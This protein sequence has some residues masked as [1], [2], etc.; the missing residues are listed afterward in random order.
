M[1]KKPD[2]D[3][4]AVLP[5]LESK[6]IALLQSLQPSD[7]LLPTVAGHWQVRDVAAHLLDGNLRTLSMLRD[8]YFGVGPTEPIDSY[9]S[10]L[11]YL[12]G[13][14][15]QWVEAMRR[16]SPQVLI[17]LMEATGRQCVAHLSSLQPYD[18]AAFSVAWAGESESANW[19]HVAR[20]YTERWHHQQQI[21]LAVGQEQALYVPEFYFPYLDTSMRALPYHYRNVDAP[22]GCC[23]EVTIRGQGGGTWVLH[24]VNAAWRLSQEATLS[25]ICTVQIEGEIAWRLFTK[26]ISLQAA[27][28]H[29]TITG[30]ERLGRHILTM[31]AVMA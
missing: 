22:E 2:I 18:T 6:L 12:N 23:I 9:S 8:G 19:F 7:W 31:L 24:R 11:Q 3:V 15:A 26:G 25:V 5:R 1:H 29:V 30:D 27:Q 17:L 21:R 10:L 4:S 20:E 28:A 13:L 14:N 16:V